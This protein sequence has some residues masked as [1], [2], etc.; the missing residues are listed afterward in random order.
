MRPQIIPKEFN[1]DNR[2][3]RCRICGELCAELS[4]S[5]EIKKGVWI[6]GGEDCIDEMNM[7]GGE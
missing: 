7:D 4:D 1:I 3:P 2:F 6:C 5:V